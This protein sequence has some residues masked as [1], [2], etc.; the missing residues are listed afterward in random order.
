[1]RSRMLITRSNA[2]I[3]DSLSCSYLVVMQLLTY[4]ADVEDVEVKMEQQMAF[5]IKLAWTVQ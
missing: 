4:L 1:M 2:N 3:Q 5:H